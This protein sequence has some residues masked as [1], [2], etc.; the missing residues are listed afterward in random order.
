MKIDSFGIHHLI[1]S[2][3]N[4]DDLRVSSERKQEQ[5]WNEPTHLSFYCLM[6]QTPTGKHALS[7]FFL[8]IRADVIQNGDSECQNRSFVDVGSCYLYVE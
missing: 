7:T 4:L 5:Q 6:R 2:C 1:R 8:G 3:V